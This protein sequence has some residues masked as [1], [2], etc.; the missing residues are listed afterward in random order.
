MTTGAETKIAGTHS[1]FS[2]PNH[3]QALSL[4]E[5]SAHGVASRAITLAYTTAVLHGTRV[6]L[7]VAAHVL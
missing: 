3:T 2:S 6:D 1:Q 7:K 5:G 4:L